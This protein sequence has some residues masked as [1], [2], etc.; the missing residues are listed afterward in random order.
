MGTLTLES[1]KELL[2]YHIHTPSEHTFSGYQADLE[3][4]FVHQGDDGKYTVIG[5]LC[6]E[7][8]DP[9]FENQFWTQLIKSFN[10]NGAV[11]NP[12]WL[13]DQVET[14]K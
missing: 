9:N 3:I 8:N 7:S 10:D 5:I 11:V 6:D 12:S 14:T 4:H 2:Q 1:I 13:L